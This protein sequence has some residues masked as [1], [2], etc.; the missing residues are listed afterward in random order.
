MAPSPLHGLNL[1]QTADSPASDQDLLGGAHN[2]PPE[3]AAQLDF[4]SSD[5]P[6]D[7]KDDKDEEQDEADSFAPEGP[8]SLDSHVNAVQP[9]AIPANASQQQQQ[10]DLNT[11]LA[12]FGIDPFLVPQLQGPTPAA[13]LH[14]PPPQYQQHLQGNQSAHAQASLAHLLAQYPFA[15]PPF[16]PTPTA[17][18]PTDLNNNAPEP[19]VSTTKK[20]RA[21]KSSTASPSTSTSLTS[22]ASVD[23]EKK[24]DTST[25]D[26][27]PSLSPAEDKRRRN[28][29]ASARF[30]LKK[31]EREAALERRAAELSLRVG[32]L[33]RECEALRRENG[34]L[35]GLVVGVTGAQQ[36]Q[37]QTVPQT[38][39]IVSPT[40]SAKRKR[41]E[42]EEEKKTAAV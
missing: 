35:K 22:P 6:E 42:L 31:K 12:G 33:E 21:R 37:Q 28:T 4:W 41:E 17:I 34:W 29:A 16:L 3:Y 9:L 30:R 10:V 40:S 7:F 39:T 36:Q 15:Q 32:A 2:F 38:P 19:T 5:T 20:T 1:V 18:T 13:Q 26:S 8:A 27:G 23:A 24:D 11:L 14:F 25:E